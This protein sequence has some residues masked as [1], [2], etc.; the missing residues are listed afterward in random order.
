MEQHEKEQN[1]VISK[2]MDDIDNLEAYARR[3]N[4][5]IEGIH[6]SPNE[7][8]RQKIIEV[9]EKKL[10]VPD[11]SPIKFM[12]IHRL[13]TP[14]HLNPHAS[15][16][17]RSVIVRFQDFSDKVWKASWSFKDKH[18]HVRED[19]TEA[20]RNRRNILLPVLKAAKRDPK[21]QRCTLRGDK[22]ILDGIKYTAEDFDK[23]PEYLKW[24]VKEERYFAQCD[25]TLFFGS[26]CFLSNLTQVLSVIRS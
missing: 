20:I 1:C 11:A 19:F 17:P 9:L 25:S 23:I 10:K 15:I 18:V 22:L 16:H 26:D 6:E 4:L 8:I 2:L 24:T 12:R 14:P 21:T 7:N 13:G 5:L 3:D